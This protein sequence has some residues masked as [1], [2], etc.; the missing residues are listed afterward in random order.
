MPIAAAV[1]ADEPQ[2]SAATKELVVK[3]AAVCRAPHSLLYLIA[4]QLTTASLPAPFL[5]IERVSE[6]L[7]I[8][9]PSEFSLGTIKAYRYARH[10][11][12]HI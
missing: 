4:S 2:A 9:P 10:A 5:V 6:L 11:T 1:P 12:R 7:P 3:M 8:E